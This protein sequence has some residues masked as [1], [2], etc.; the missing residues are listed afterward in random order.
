MADLSQWSGDRKS[1]DKQA[2]QSLDLYHYLNDEIG[3]EKLTELINAG[4]LPTGK[5]GVKARELARGL[6][7]GWAQ[8]VAVA[9]IEDGVIDE[10]AID[11]DQSLVAI[12]DWIMGVL[13]G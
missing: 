10:S 5:A 7:K 4:A 9:W 1:P 2:Q 13:G 3:G 6:A 8:T 12:V 11:A